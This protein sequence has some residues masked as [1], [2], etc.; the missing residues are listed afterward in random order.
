[1]LLNGS[2]CVSVVLYLALKCKGREKGHLNCLQIPPREK[3]V[4][5]IQTSKHVWHPAEISG[6]KSISL[7]IV[8]FIRLWIKLIVVYATT[9]T[10]VATLCLLLCT[11]SCMFAAFACYVFFPQTVK[12]IRQPSCSCDTYRA[13][14]SMDLDKGIWVFLRAHCN[15]LWVV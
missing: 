14:I 1:M 4:G 11:T 9:S 2:P 12:K 10:S 8:D 7:W 13:P 5:S 15:Q 6:N 3:P